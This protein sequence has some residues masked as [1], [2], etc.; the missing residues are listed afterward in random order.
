MSRYYERE[1]SE[2]IQAV[3]QAAR[4]C[5]TVRGGPEAEVLDKRDKSPVTVA[6]FGSQAVVCRAWGSRFRT[7][8]VNPEDAAELGR[9]GNPAVLDEVVG[10]VRA[11]G[12]DADRNPSPAEVCGWIDRG[13]SSQ[14]CDRFWAIDPIDGT[15]GFLRNEQ[16]AVALALIVEGQVVVAALSCPNLPFDSASA[17]AS[18]GVIF[19]AVQGHGAIVV[20]LEQEEE[21][22]PEFLPVQVSQRTDP[23]VLRFCESVESGHSAHG[24][25]AAIAAR[26]GIVT[27]P[28]G[29]TARP[30]TGSLRGARRKSISACRPGL[31]TARRYG[32]TPPEP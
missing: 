18:R 21:Y 16:Y 25:A 20:P 8:T 7:L 29:W 24:D 6:D 4:L 12:L 26:L 3:R 22:E 31:I 28:S 10:Q 13:G 1:Q 15:K 14:Y 23:A 32:I 30:S 2:A 9:S 11:L 17:A 27:P 19:A 5:L